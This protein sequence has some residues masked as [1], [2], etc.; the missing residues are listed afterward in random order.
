MA[1]DADFNQAFDLLIGHEGGYTN[2]PNDPGNWTGG[3]VNSGTLRGTK[4]GISAASY[5]T[6][7][8]KNLGLQEAQDIYRRDFWN[9]AGCPDCSPRL[10]LALFDAA[11]NNGVSRAVKWLQ[12]AVGVT[13]DG[14]YGSQ[15]RAAVQKAMAKDPLDLDLA[16]EVH[17][18]RIFFM[19]S[20]ADWKNFGLGWA[21]RLASIPAQ[22]G[23]HWPKG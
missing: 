8:I 4:Y 3:K 17:A 1:T 10:A 2:N 7:D 13:Q 16:T 19:A 18:Q 20:L 6:L 21:R 15:T 23:H 9:K 11:V 12:G 14:G 5:P 22:G